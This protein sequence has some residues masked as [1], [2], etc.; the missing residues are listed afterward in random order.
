M[1]RMF[2]CKRIGFDK[3]LKQ[4][5]TFVHE[6]I[7]WIIRAIVKSEV[8]SRIVRG[9]N[10]VRGRQ[11]DVIVADVVAQKL[12]T[13]DIQN[14]EKKTTSMTL[15]VNTSH[16]DFDSKEDLFSVGQVVPCRDGRMYI[17]TEIEEIKYSFVDI[18]MEF[19]GISITEINNHESK[20]L[21]LEDRLN[22][23]GWTIYRK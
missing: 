7:T 15:R 11:F 9:F 19:N 17:L 20:K 10:G 3:S 14:A 4:N 12:G 1:L 16:I 21:N 6:G 8:K 18:S 2:E 23:R 13:F 5:D 22:E